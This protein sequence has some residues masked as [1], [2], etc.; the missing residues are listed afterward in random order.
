MAHWHQINGRLSVGR[1]WQYVQVKVCSN[2]S[3]A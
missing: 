3:E 1:V 2:E